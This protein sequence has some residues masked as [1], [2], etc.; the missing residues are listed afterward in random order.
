[1][2]RWN[3]RSRFRWIDSGTGRSVTW[4]GF[5]LMSF[6]IRKVI[7]MTRRSTG[8]VHTIRLM[9]NASI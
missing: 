6:I 3:F 9:M 1:L 2:S 8:I 4:K 7:R 5:P